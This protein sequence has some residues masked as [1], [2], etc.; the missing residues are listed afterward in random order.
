MHMVNDI[1][2]SGLFNVGAW[3]ELSE[4]CIKALYY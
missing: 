4:T 2:H 3:H 1:A